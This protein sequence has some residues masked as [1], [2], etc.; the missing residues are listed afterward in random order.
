MIERGPG[1]ETHGGVASIAGLVIKR[2]AELRQMHVL[3]ASHAERF[4]DAGEL[5]NLFRPVSVALITLQDGMFA[6]QRKPRFGVIEFRGIG[7]PAGVRVALGTLLFEQCRCKSLLM[8]TLVT[9]VA[10]LA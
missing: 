10:V 1:G 2:S 6:G 4:L 3:V 9:R 7:I 8:R 5:E